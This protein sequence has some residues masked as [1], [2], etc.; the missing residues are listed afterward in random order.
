MCTFCLSEA[1]CYRYFYNSFLLTVKHLENETGRWYISTN[2]TFQLQSTALHQQFEEKYGRPCLSSNE[3]A[4][5]GCSGH[6]GCRGH[7][8]ELAASPHALEGRSRNL[9]ITTGSHCGHPGV[10]PAASPCAHEEGSRNVTITTGSHCG[11]PGVE[12]AASLPAQEGCSRNFTITTLPLPLTSVPQ[13]HQ[14]RLLFVLKC[15]L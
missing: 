13:Q 10:E 3:E 7:P 12:P 4:T 11:H 14:E 6:R 9:T 15:L 8:V 5:Q 2:L 1:L